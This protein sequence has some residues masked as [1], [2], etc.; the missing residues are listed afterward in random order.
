MTELAIGTI[1]HLESSKA[2]DV[3][4][5]SALHD[6]MLHPLV[7]A[8]LMTTR[9]LVDN[10]ELRL[11]HT[12]DAVSAIIAGNTD[13]INQVNGIHRRISGRLPY[14]AGKWEADTEFKASDPEL[15]KW[16]FTTLFVTR[17]YAY[18]EI[19]GP[20]SPELKEQYYGSKR[21]IGEQLLIPESYL[22]RDYE[23][24]AD[25]YDGMVN[26]IGGPSDDL[27]MTPMAE[28]VSAAL[29]GMKFGAIPIPKILGK[30]ASAALMSPAARQAYEFTWGFPQKVAWSAGK[31]ALRSIDRRAQD[32]IQAEKA[33][34]N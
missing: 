27:A 24:M 28:E 9:R 16:V 18:E 8:G 31:A 26:S 4:G 11:Q 33:A 5:L 19:Y 17:L 32:K 10:P 21:H 13:T 29:L 34:A 1:D 30:T 15:L 14:A 3:H 2:I 12:A 7:V 25:Y 20:L 6:Q 23:A 22:P